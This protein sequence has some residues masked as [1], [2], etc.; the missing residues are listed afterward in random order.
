[1]PHRHTDDKKEEDEFAFC[2]VLSLHNKDR[3]HDVQNCAQNEAD[4]RYNFVELHTKKRFLGSSTK[5][6]YITGSKY[7]GSTGLESEK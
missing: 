6:F 2:L 7:P 5:G 1:M 3:E 4:K